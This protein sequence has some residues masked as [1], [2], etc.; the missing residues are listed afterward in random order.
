ML[1]LKKQSGLP[2]KLD[3]NKQIIFSPEVNRVKVD[4]RT[5]NEIKNVLMDPYSAS[6]KTKFYYMYRNLCLN[7]NKAT[8]A[9]HGLRYDITVI[10]PILLGKEFNKTAGHFHKLVPNTNLTYTEVYEV[11]YGEAH[12]LLQKNDGTDFIIIK[13]KPGDKVV[14]PPNYAHVTTN[15]TNKVLVAANWMALASKSSYTAVHNKKGLMHYYTKDGFIKNKN[16]PKTVEPREAKPTFVKEF[17]L[18][19]KPMY[20]SELSKLDFLKNPQKYLEIFNQLYK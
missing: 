16:Y 8:I 19:K 18:A 20:F 1:N 12:F 13:A 15:P 10:P 14:V 5:Y 6:K 3:K 11:L 4:I 17:D 2:I 9:N 7:K